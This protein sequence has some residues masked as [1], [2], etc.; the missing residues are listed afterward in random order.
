MTTVNTRGVFLGCKYAI[1]RFL[2]QDPHPANSRGD[3]T[4]G[5]I[6]N[7]AS[8][9]G[10][11]AFTKAPCYVTTKHAVVGM[12]KQIA[13]DYAQDRIHCNCL[14]PGFV[15]TAM[16]KTNITVND[17]AADAIGALHPWNALGTPEDIAKAAVFLA[18]DDAYVRTE[19]YS[20]TCC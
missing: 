5:W 2:E 16:I 9:L 15:Q 19:L 10:L 14:C 6:V 11:V 4:R 7:T 3:Q 1:Q 18:S 20:L 13:I 12:T 8:M 17:E